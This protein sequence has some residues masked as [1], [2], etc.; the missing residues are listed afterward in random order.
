MSAEY[1]NE[2]VQKQ[3]LNN[4][5]KAWTPSS[6]THPQPVFFKFMVIEMF[7]VFYTYEHKL[8]IT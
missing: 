5:L 7:H 2:K 4:I 1:Q 3:I 8:M 6:F